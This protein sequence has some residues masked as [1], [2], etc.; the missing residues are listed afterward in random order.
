MAA[1]PTSTH[2]RNAHGYALLG[3]GRYEDAVRE[4][5]AYARIAPREPNP[6]DSLGEAYLKAG[7]AA[8]AVEAYSRALAVDATFAPSLNLRAWSL[9]SLGRYDAALAEHVDKAHLRAVMLSRIG[10]YRD[11][12]D[13]LAGGE[14]ELTAQGDA[15]NAGGVRL[16]AALLALERGDHAR[17]LRDIAAADTVFEGRASDSA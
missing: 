5:E 7:D 16:T 11:A 13:V 17:A 6:H 8:K 3:V 9:A 15:T 4:F 1:L 12:A 10:R 14:S 2:T